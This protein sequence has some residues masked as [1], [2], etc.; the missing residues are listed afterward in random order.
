MDEFSCLEVISSYSGH[1]WLSILCWI[2]IVPLV[3]YTFF[4]VIQ[5]WPLACQQSVIEI[6]FNPVQG[7]EFEGRTTESNDFDLLKHRRFNHNLTA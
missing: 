2:L 3:L 4:H 7:I 5:L 6:L 1:F